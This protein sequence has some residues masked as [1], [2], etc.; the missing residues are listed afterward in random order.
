MFSLKSV[1]R[2]SVIRK[3]GL[4]LLCLGISWFY[5]A[6]IVRVYVAQRS[7][8]SFEIES[9][10]RAVRLVPDDAEF[11]HQLGLRLSDSAQDVRDAIA[12]LQKAVALNPSRGQ[13]WLDLAS[14]YQ[15][16]GNVE[17][18]REAVQSAITAEPDNP[19]IAESAAQFLLASGQLDRALP[20][21]KQALERNPDAADNIFRVCWQQIPDANLILARAIPANPALQL[22]FLRMLA[23]QGEAA[24]ASNVWQF[25]VAAHKSFD[26]KLSFFYFDYLLK[27]Y[28]VAGF[29]RGWRELASLAPEISAYLPDGNL[30]VN[31]SFEQGLLNSGFDWRHEPADHI[32]V[33]VDTRVA[34]SGVRS[35]SLVY[36]GKPA[37]DSGWAEFVPV[38][39]DA[40][41]EFSAWIKSENVT[42]S[43]GP[44][45]ALVDAIS[46]ANLLVTD[47]VLDTH[48]W[49]ELKGT[50]HVPAETELLAVKI[51]RIPANTR[52]RG[53]VWI[54]DLRLVKK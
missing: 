25:I 43:S 29:R 6:R 9:I 50:L 38:D 41:Y 18:E 14:A 17:E 10:Q 13:Y 46:G 7:A 30:I 19:E 8:E 21:F 33:G 40:D 51:V 52:I 26:P 36:D 54:D 32:A 4:V 53:Q 48:P 28:D 5:V 42:S 12:N 34:H 27:E 39:A 22:E 1:F 49:Q 37:Y 3:A 11:P 44:R 45:I 20:L 47:D 15:T 2:N 31:G 23:D 35:L 24:A 16:S